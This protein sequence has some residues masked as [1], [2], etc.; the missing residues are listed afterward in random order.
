FDIGKAIRATES[1]EV[2]AADLPERAREVGDAEEAVGKALAA[3]RDIRADCDA[4]LKGKKALP[5]LT[6]RLSE[7]VGK[8]FGKAVDEDFPAAQKALAGFRAA[9]EA[10]KAD[11][12][13]AKG[14]NDA[15]TQL[16]DRLSEV[17]AALDDPPDVGE[18]IATLAEME[19]DQR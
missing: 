2:R 15:M 10:G 13:K 12:D 11:A 9:L 6:A 7:P 14:A 17:R 5:G 3:I 16:I 18:L 1:K 19:W 8:P 4:A